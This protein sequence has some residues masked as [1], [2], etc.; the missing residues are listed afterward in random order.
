MPLRSAPAQKAL[1]AGAGEDRDAQVV[2]VAHLD[3]VR[4]QF[5][6]RGEVQRVQ[7]FGPVQRDQRDVGRATSNRTVMACSYTLGDDRLRPPQTY[8][9]WPVT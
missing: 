1:L 4:A 9:V 8:S 6:Q 5:L 2:A 3:Q 7:R